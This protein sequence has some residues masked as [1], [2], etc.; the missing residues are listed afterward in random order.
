MTA[1]KTYVELLEEV[2]E[3]RQQERAWAEELQFWLFGVRATMGLL[4]T[5]ADLWCND[6]EHLTTEELTILEKM[7]RRTVLDAT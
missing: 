4:K 2:A 1:E 6:R 7:L 5:A 3:L